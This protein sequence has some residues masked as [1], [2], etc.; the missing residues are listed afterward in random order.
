MQ[1]ASHWAVV[2]WQGS[3]RAPFS[4]TTP[5]SAQVW[6]SAA[7]HQLIRPTSRPLF[8]S[9]HNNYFSFIETFILHILKEL[10]NLSPE[11]LPQTYEIFER[12]NW[13]EPG[14]RLSSPSLDSTEQEDS[15]DV[16]RTSLP[17]F[18][19]RGFLP[20]CTHYSESVS[21][22]CLLSKSSEM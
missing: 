6:R 19:Q 18:W 9:F 21:R 17:I 13:M 1:Y 20:N 14:S 3:L 2:T 12:N 7:D 15:S 8:S 10:E 22:W 5:A 16:F 4:W 11:T